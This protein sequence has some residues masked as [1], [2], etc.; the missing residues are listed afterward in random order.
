MRT[1]RETDLEEELDK[2]RNGY[3][4]ACYACEPVGE[5][6]ERLTALYDQMVRVNGNMKVE[7]DRLEDEIE[8]LTTD[9]DE[10][11]RLWK[12]ASVSVIDLQDEIEKLK[13]DRL[14]V[15]E[16]I[17]KLE[18]EVVRLATEKTKWIY[19]AVKAE[20]NDP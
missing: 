20:R 16:Y 9:R 1:Q 10:W 15:K 14:D 3:K 8:R 11:E 5:Q 19:K 7:N 17:A 4:G 12:K 2:Y 18:A 13:E 6:N